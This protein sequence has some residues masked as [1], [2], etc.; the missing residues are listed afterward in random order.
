M[1]DWRDKAACQGEGDI[2]FGPE[3]EPPEVREARVQLAEM[4]CNGCPVRQQCNELAAE[5]AAM[6]GVWAGVDRDV[7]RLMRRRRARQD[8]EGEAA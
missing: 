7:I 4:I 2:F 5:K 8:G 3:R 1:S 6:Y